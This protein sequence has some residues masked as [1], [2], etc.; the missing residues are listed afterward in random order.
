MYSSSLS[1]VNEIER[2]LHVVNT[3][4]TVWYLFEEMFVNVNE[5]LLS[6]LIEL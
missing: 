4:I 6:H 5:M 3:P 1:A 2:L